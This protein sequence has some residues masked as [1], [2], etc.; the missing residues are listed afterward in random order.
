MAQYPTPPTTV[1]SVL[2]AA[3]VT[4]VA[5]LETAVGTYGGG[6]DIS[7]DLAAAEA[8]IGTPATV[9]GETDLFAIAAALAARI[10]A[11]EA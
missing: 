1:N 2:A 3:T 7:V 6:D 11:L 4:D 8:N 9:S 5:A 10:T